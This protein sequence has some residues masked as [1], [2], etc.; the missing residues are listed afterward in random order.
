MKAKK[1]THSF[2]VPQDRDEADRMIAML[3]EARRDLARREADMNDELAAVKERHERAAAPLKGLAADLMAGIETWCAANR[4]ALTQGGRVKF[5]RFAAGEV[6]WRV[7]PPRV[8]VR[9][10][11]QVIAALKGLGL[12]R[13]VRVTETVNRE[14]ILAEPEAVAGIA[15]I[16]IGSAGEDFVVEPYEEALSDG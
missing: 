11:E 2:R 7:R 1:L 3:G 5:A 9:A 13:L 14:A 10:Q 8:T 4:A 6:K 15:G 16:S 12:A